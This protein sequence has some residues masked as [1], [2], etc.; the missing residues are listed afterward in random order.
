MSINGRLR[1]LEQ[2]AGRTYA[3]GECPN[4]VITAILEEGEAVSEDTPRCRLCGEVHVLEIVEEIIDPE[5]P[6]P[7]AKANES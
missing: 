1:K 4:R 5:N 7:D 2:A 3:P 6:A